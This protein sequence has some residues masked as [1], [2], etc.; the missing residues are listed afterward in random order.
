MYARNK[1]FFLNNIAVYEL[2]VYGYLI[3]IT[4]EPQISEDLLQNTMEKAWEKM[5]QLREPSKVQSWLFSIA[6]NEANK[7]YRYHDCVYSYIDDID[8][9]DYLSSGSCVECADILENLIKSYDLFVL[10]EALRRLDKKDKKLIEMYYFQGINQR[11]I[12]E[13]L[14]KNHSTVRVN[15]VRA[16]DKIRRIYIKIEAGEIDVKLK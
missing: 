3:S 9:N 8:F 2:D 12:A 15:L 5:A 14:N 7:Y 1:S 11:Q 13:R 16:I 10:R 4:E 6:K